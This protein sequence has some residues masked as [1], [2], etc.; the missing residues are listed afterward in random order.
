[1]HPARTLACPSLAWTDSPRPD[2]RPRTCSRGEPPCAY[3]ASLSRERLFRPQGLAAELYNK[4]AVAPRNHRA[5]SS[6]RGHK[7][8]YGII[9]GLVLVLAVSMAGTFASSLVAIES[10]KDTVISAD[11]DCS[12]LKVARSYDFALPLVLMGATRDVTLKTAQGVYPDDDVTLQS[13]V[14]TFSHTL[15]FPTPDSKSVVNPNVDTLY[16]SAFLDIGLEP[17]VLTIPKENG[18]RLGLF[19]VMDFWSN[20]IGNPYV[21]GS[22]YNVCIYLTPHLASDEYMKCPE[23]VESIESNTTNLWLLAR[24]APRDSS[25][26]SDLDLANEMQNQYELRNLSGWRAGSSPNRAWLTDGANTLSARDIVEEMSAAEF[27]NISTQLM[28]DNKPTADD[29]RFVRE[30]W[31][32]VEESSDAVL[33]EGVKLAKERRPSQKAE[34]FE[35]TEGWSGISD[36]IGTFGTDYAL[37]AVIAD[38]GFAANLPEDAVYFIK[39][40]LNGALKHTLR[41]SPPPPVDKTRG[42]WSITSYVG[43]YLV[44]DPRYP[45][46][47]RA[48]VVSSLQSSLFEESNGDTVIH[49]QANDPGEGKNWLYVPAEESGASLTLTARFYLPEDAIFPE[50]TWTLP[51][52]ETH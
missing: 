1:M 49:I 13:I 26:N 18:I 41:L 9:A 4:E 40:F 5:E 11:S 10:A 37:R 28:A 34:L 33:S 29:V 24:T 44:A 51:R 27:F 46:G 47:N 30:V 6:K 23:G 35:R 45:D 25:D 43:L 31:T 52:I 2:P 42:F 16:S 8:L 20:V 36:S 3:T 32:A 38:V 14:N 39:P 17:V 7:L 12:V 19:Q 21:R 50:K 15:R 48:A 22:M